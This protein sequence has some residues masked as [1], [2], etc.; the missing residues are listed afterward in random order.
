MSIFSVLSRSNMY[1]YLLP[2]VCLVAFSCNKEDAPSPPVINPPVVTD[3][4]FTNPLL[5]SGPDPWVIQKDTIY[6]YTH[7]TGDRL[8]I[9]KTSKMSAL[10]NAV[11]TTIWSP[12]AT[13]AYSK[14]IWAPELHYLQNKW[15]MYF[16]ADDGSN[17]THRMYV[18]ENPSADPTAGTWTFKGKVADA[19]DKWAI[20]GTVFEH[21]AQL[22]MLWSGW[23]GNTD[24]EQDIFIAKM[25]DPWTISSNRVLISSPTFSW[26][27]MGALPTVNEGPEVLK[28][29]N[30]NLFVSYSASGCWTDA[31]AMGLL[32][33]TNGGDPMNAADWIKTPTPVF[34]TVG[35]NGAYAPGHNSFFKSRDGTEDWI[36]YHANSTAGLGCGNS[37]SPRMQK[38]T[39]N[40]DGSPNFGSPVKINT[41]IKKPSGE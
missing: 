39:W 19:T 9:Y 31:Y 2:L 38:F 27:K 34:S 12:P 30:G 5:S 15:Y 40:A 16:A 32:K 24:G 1:K 35:A 10:S 18:L 4:S 17:A 25:S 14:D 26:E 36:L 22:Y 29:S 20:D 41:A 37:R 23:Q 13:G 8:V 28:N 7:T 3:T 11:I 21:N 33:L 6:Y